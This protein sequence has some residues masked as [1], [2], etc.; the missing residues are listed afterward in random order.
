MSSP[1]KASSLQKNIKVP[2]KTKLI[3]NK[4]NWTQQPKKGKKPV[5]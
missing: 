5:N 4:H 1:V 2:S 3:M